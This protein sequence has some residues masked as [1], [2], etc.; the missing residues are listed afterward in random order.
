MNKTSIF[1][2][3]PTLEQAKEVE[4][5]LNREEIMT[6]IADN[7]PPVDITFS[8][9]TLQHQYEIR[10]KPSDFK[11]AENIL[12][13][14]AEALLDHLDEDYYLFAFTDDELYDILIKPDEWSSFDY[15][16]SKKILIK[17]GK[18]IDEKLL[19]SLKTK[20]LKELAKP[21]DNQMTWIV[22]GYV[23]SFIGG[24]LG[25]II[26]YFL[27]TSKKTLPNGQK[28]F[29]YSKADRNHGKHIFFIGL[30][31]FPILLVFRVIKEIG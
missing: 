17:Q 30:V 14:N 1:R 25:M 18:P 31:I 7:V 10:I 5:L 11:K 9:S 22:L 6:I 4:L 29:S 13:K 26:G 8:G 20:R 2:K 19:N 16:L 23:T 27:W 24:F 12:E 21:E 3:F 15:T 28:V